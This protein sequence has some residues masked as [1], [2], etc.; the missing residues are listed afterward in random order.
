MFIIQDWAGN[1]CF[2]GKEFTDWDDA[3]CFLCEIL[4]DDYETDRGEYYIV[5][6]P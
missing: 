4:G 5:E 6:K 3:E 2:H 1:V